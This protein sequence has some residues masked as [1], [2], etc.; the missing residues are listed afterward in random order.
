MRIITWVC[1]K[2]DLDKRPL[3]TTQV[4]DFLQPACTFSWMWQG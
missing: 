3:T 2:D 4:N 1:I